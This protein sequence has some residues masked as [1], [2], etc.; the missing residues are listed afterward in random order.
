MSAAAAAWQA[1]VDERLIA[2]CEAHVRRG[3]RLMRDWSVPTKL[4]APTLH[5]D[6]ADWR[7]GFLR[8]D[9]ERDLPTEL[10]DDLRQNMPQ[11]LLRDLYRPVREERW[12][13]REL[14]EGTGDRGGFAAMQTVRDARKLE[15]PPR[16]E[17][18]TR[19]VR[20]YQA[21]R[22]A[23]VSDRWQPFRRDDER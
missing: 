3:E 23:L 12:V 11:A 5:V 4:R 20:E 6:P 1:A 9:R 8:V 2:R 15:P 18:L 7:A 22:R 21:W 10:Q 16:V 19:V 14:V 17:S 13:E